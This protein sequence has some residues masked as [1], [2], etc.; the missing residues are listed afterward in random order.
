M[1]SHET[2][3]ATVAL[4]KRTINPATGKGFSYR[5]I[6]KLLG[7]TGQAAYFYAGKISGRCP[8]CLRKLHKLK[9]HDAG[10]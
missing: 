9:N 3:R 2:N 6:G 5:E 10:K 7:M 1:T 4:L 8:E